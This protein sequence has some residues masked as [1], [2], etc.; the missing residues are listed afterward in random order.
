MSQ[1]P[2]QYGQ[3]L[4]HDDDQPVCPRHPDEPVVGRCVRCGRPVC[5]RC[6]AP[7]PAGTVCTDCAGAAAQQAPRRGGTTSLFPRAGAMPVTWG[8]VVLCVLVYLGQLVTRQEL[9]YSLAY[10]PVLTEQEPW[11]MLTAAFVHGSF[12]HLA[13]NMYTLWIFGQALEPRM[14]PWRYGLVFLLSVLGGSAAVWLLGN[15]YV[16]TVGASGGI[17]GLFGAFFAWTRFRG[18]DTRGLLVLIGIN[19][20]FGFVVSGI[21]WQAHVGGLVT[22]TLVAWLLD[23]AGSRGRRRVR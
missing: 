4:E 17:F 6:A 10:A 15:P 21:S 16:W 20:V 9:T 12:L 18:G 23:L 1:Q 22:G 5:R 13:M 19:L 8:I 3:R 14:G 11:R 7:H 2:P